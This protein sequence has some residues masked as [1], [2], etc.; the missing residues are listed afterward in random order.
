M[1][2]QKTSRNIIVWAWAAIAALIVAS[3]FYFSAHEIMQSARAKHA[4]AAFQATTDH[5]RGAMLL[6]IGSLVFIIGGIITNRQVVSLVAVATSLVLYEGISWPYC[7]ALN[8]KL[9]PASATKLVDDALVTFFFGNP[10]PPVILLGALELALL[11]FA[12]TTPWRARTTWPERMLAIGA[13]FVCVVATTEAL[14]FIAAV[15]EAGSKLG[16]VH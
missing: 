2:V 14:R 8:P 16:G 13:F 1:P 10:M 3:G 6:A 15:F 11:I 7:A 12:I 5:T 4:A 9:A